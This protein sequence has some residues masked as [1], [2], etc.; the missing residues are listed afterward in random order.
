MTTGAKIYCHTAYSFDTLSRV[1][2]YSLPG[3]A[4][5]INWRLGK[6]L[7]RKIQLSS[8]VIILTTLRVLTFSIFQ[9]FSVRYLLCVRLFKI[10][11]IF[12]SPL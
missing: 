12:K 1:R 3:N 8:P 11:S 5:T 10:R 6:K 9:V 4:E 7:C 2:G